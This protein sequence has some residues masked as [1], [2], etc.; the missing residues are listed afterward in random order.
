MNFTSEDYM[1][2]IQTSAY[3]GMGL[4][5]AVVVI[6]LISFWCTG[7]CTRFTLS[8]RIVYGF[9]WPVADSISGNVHGLWDSIVFTIYNHMWANEN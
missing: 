9:F 3:V 2:N 6:Y 7:H 5:I 4:N 1:D 8:V